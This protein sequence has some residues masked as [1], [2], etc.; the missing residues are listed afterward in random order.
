[1]LE[2][3]GNMIKKIIVFLMFLVIFRCFAQDPEQD[4]GKKILQTYGGSIVAVKI[5]TE[6]N[7]LAKGKEGQKQELKTET[8]G[9][10]ITK[11]GITICSLSASNPS[12]ALASAM[13]MGE[14]E[15]GFSVESK[16]TDIKIRF[17]DGQEVPADILLRDK[18]L[19]ILFI[20]PK[21]KPS[22]PITSYVNLSDSASADILDKI[23]IVSR[24][25]QIANWNTMICI[26]R[27]DGIIEKPRLYYVPDGDLWS[28][29]GVPVFTENG[30]II[31]IVLLKKI[32]PQSSGMGGDMF[33]PTSTLG[34]LPCIVPAKD[35]LDDMSQIQT[36]AKKQVN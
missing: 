19:D 35:V 25:G 1:M 27:I 6:E 22:S 34:M 2:P 23:F 26:S 11:D 15:S 30:K 28:A 18:N 24:L 31:G 14:E 32:K 9:T 12:E 8:Y 5:V 10:V 29:L 7:W 16:I 36:P 17:T 20:K 21:K 33:N 13:D 3:G 4:A